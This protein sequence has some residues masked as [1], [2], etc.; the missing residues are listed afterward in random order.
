VQGYSYD[1]VHLP[2]LRVVKVTAG[3]APSA[4]ELPRLQIWDVFVRSKASPHR[5]EAAEVTEADGKLLF[6]DLDGA[7]TGSFNSSDL[8]GH[9]LAEEAE[10]I[11]KVTE[12]GRCPV[13]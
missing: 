9:R 10:L 12:V 4:E 7:L 6:T 2:R 8:Q 1:A 5:L 3:E 13:A 11:L